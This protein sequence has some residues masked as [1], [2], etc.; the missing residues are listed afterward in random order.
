MFC[1]IN[2]SYKL[3]VKLKILKC[4]ERCIKVYSYANKKILTMYENIFL[5]V[6]KVKMSRKF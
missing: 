5:L 1:S 4:N 2:D 3:F 6:F